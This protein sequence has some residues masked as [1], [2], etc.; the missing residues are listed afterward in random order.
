MKATTRKLHTQ[1]TLWC[2]CI[3][4]ECLFDALCV[5]SPVLSLMQISKARVKSR[6]KFDVAWNRAL[7]RLQ[8]SHIF[9]FGRNARSRQA[10]GLER[11][12]K[13]R[14]RHALKAW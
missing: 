7:A 1:F 10:I 2:V 11:E 13:R 5:S 4:Q 9:A 14:E 3:G 6:V 12:W 8:N